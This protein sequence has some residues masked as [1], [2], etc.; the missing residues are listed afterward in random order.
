MKYIRN[1]NSQDEYE[2][3]RR[4]PSSILD[5]SVSLAGTAINYYDK[6]YPFYV[7]A[8][9]NIVISR[10]D[11]LYSFDG[12]TWTET[13]TNISVPA[14]I[15]IYLKPENY[16]SSAPGTYIK[17]TEGTYNIGGDFIGG[18]GNSGSWSGDCFAGEEGLISAE[19]LII[20]G[21]TYNEDNK[22]RR[23]TQGLFEG[24]INLKKAPKAIF[25]YSKGHYNNGTFSFA[26]AFKGCTSL[27]EAPTILVDLPIGSASYTSN[28][29]LS[30]SFYG[31]SNLKKVEILCKTLSTADRLQ[32]SDWL[33]GVSETGLITLN[34]KASSTFLSTILPTI[35]EGWEVRYLDIDADKYYIKFTIDGVEHLAE[36]GMTWQTWVS[37][38]YNTIGLTHYYSYDNRNC[39]L[40]N[41]DEG[42]LMLNGNNVHH[43]HII[44]ANGADYTFKSSVYIQHIDGSLYTSNEWATGGFENSDANG[45]AVVDVENNRGVVVAKSEIED[46]IWGPAD[47]SISTSSDFGSGESNTDMIINTLGDNGTYAAKSAKAYTFPNG[48]SGFLPSKDEFSLIISHYEQISGTMSLIGGRNLRFNS[49]AYWTSSQYNEAKS[50]YMH[51]RTILISSISKGYSYSIRPIILLDYSNFENLDSNID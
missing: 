47:V 28:Y 38:K 9:D 11:F 30:Q 43:N 19:N 50:Y 8:I 2:K 31:C 35:P 15:R 14:G 12:I 51:S 10:A 1:F 44:S 41:I 48:N 22:K 4:L 24:C 36:Y 21:S 46:V 18:S 45:V 25:T 40:Y 27:E 42:Y 37:S 20:N 5:N 39:P 32:A 16:M 23:I 34:Y 49:D 3:Y 33:S 13:T 17:V 26:Q 7:E 29:Y 6:L